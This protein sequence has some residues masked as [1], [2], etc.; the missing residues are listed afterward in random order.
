MN[1]LRALGTLLTAAI[2]LSCSA[3]NEQEHVYETLATKFGPL[4]YMR[5][6]YNIRLNG[7]VLVQPNRAKDPYGYQ[8]SLVEAEAYAAPSGRSVIP[9]PNGPIS[10][11]NIDR[12][13]IGE[14]A[15]GGCARQFLI[16]DLRG[17]A[18]FVSERFG[19]NPDGKSCHSFKS[20]KWGSTESTIYLAGNLKYVYFTGG[21]VIGPVD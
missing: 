10:K 18:P 15:D 13:V 1:L 21:K 16:V 9:S 6:S 19:L 4:E 17:P 11:R 12:V 7:Q 2:S 5:P 3:Q 8:L 20:A 14:V